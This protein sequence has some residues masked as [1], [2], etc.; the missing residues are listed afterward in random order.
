MSEWYFAY[1]AN[2]ASE[3]L[4]RRGLVSLES[5]AARL[6]DHELR[7]EEPGVP[8]IEPVFA[9]IA[10][11]PGRHV[12]GVLHR[13]SEADLAQLDQFEGLGYD[14]RGGLVEARDLGSVDAFFYA[15]RRHVRG[16]RPSRRYVRLLVAGAREHRLP[17]EWIDRLAAEPTF[18]VPI[19]SHLGPTM[20]VVIEQL[21][22][23]SPRAE[24][25]LRRRTG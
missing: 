19:V 15:A 8:W 23:R 11:A 13:L 4:A 12:H 24:A 16:R 5:H 14:R 20:M 9:S 6:D 17:P 21:T 7:F 3:V 2:M 1:G 18:H 25:W 10:E 22:K